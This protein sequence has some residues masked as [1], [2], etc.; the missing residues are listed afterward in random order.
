MR[1]SVSEVPLIS[2]FCVL[3]VC[4]FCQL[5]SCPPQVRLQLIVSRRVAP[6]PARCCRQMWFVARLPSRAPT[7]HTRHVPQTRHRVSRAR[8]SSTHHT[9]L[10]PPACAACVCVSRVQNLQQQQRER[11]GSQANTTVH[12]SHAAPRS[13]HVANRVSERSFLWC[14]FVCRRCCPGRN[15][16]PECPSGCCRPC[17]GRRSCRRADWPCH[18]HPTARSPSRAPHTRAVRT[19]KGDVRMGTLCRPASDRCLI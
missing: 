3:C 9:P 2:V 7:V 8:A 12:Y 5:P 19:R 10:L 18:H 13:G 14:L 16:R 17:S 6:A 4:V 15:R 1:D 11:R